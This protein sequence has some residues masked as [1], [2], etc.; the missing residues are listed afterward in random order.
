MTRSRARRWL[1]PVGLLVL[2]LVCAYIIV[3]LVGRIDWGAVRD[4]IGAVALWQFPILLIVLAIRQVLN[5]TPLALFIEGLGVRRAVQNDQAA[6]LTSTIAPPPADMVLRLAMFDSW[7]IPISHGLA[8]ALMNILTFYATRFTVPAVGLVV[9]LS[10]GAPYHSIYTWTAVVGAVVAIVLLGVLRAVVLR[11]QTAIWV[12]TTGGRIVRR[13]RHSVDPEAWAA[14]AVEFRSHV[15]H[16]TRRGLPLSLLLLVVMVV[17][18]GLLLATCLRCVG[19]AAGDLPAAEVVGIFLVAYPLTLFP[20]AGVGVL[21]ATLLAAFVEIAGLPLEPD[22][23]AG[24]VLYRVVTLAVPMLF[25]LA[26]IALWRR[27][28][29]EKEPTHVSP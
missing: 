22:I 29:G 28:G 11:E 13:V 7:G 18:D 19:V 21:D 4:A 15:L 24:L 27:T 26:S 1:R 6:T 3:G 25:G 23:V 17:V 2:S 10:S 5:A 9:V 8:G 20:L 16:R 12:G 14:Q